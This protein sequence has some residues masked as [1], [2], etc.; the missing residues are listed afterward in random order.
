[1]S[2]PPSAAST[3]TLAI[4]ARLTDMPRTVS[5]RVT[6]SGL[7]VAILLPDDVVDEQQGVGR[8][9]AVARRR[10]AGDSRRQHLAG[11]RVAR[12][13]HRDGGARFEIASRIPEAP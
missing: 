10:A 1:M 2:L 6:N 8:V 11:R 13:E 3:S 4:W 12:D 7:I 9:G 5:S